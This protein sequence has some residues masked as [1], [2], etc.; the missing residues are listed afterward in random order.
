MV[1]N[2]IKVKLSDEKKNA[3]KQIIKIA[4]DNDFEITPYYINGDGQ[5]Y[6]VSHDDV[7]G[8]IWDDHYVDGIA[9]DKYES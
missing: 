4:N 1:I 8:S 2:M 9:I 5:V 6:F 7:D 3:L